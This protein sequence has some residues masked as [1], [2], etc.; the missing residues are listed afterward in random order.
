[1]KTKKTY[2]D[3]NP[4]KVERLV[5]EQL[6][7][8]RAE[9]E[10]SKYP[11]AKLRKRDF[12]KKGAYYCLLHPIIW[13]Y[14]QF[15]KSR[16]NINSSAGQFQQHLRGLKNNRDPWAVNAPDMA[17]FRQ[18]LMHWGI[19]KYDIGNY[20]R[21]MQNQMFIFALLGLWGVYLLTGSLFAQLN[22][23]PLTLIGFIMVVTR[24]W[25][26]QILVNRRFVFF[27]D[28]FLWGLFSWVGTETPFA[29]KKRL[30]KEAQY[31]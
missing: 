25:R 27:K 15:K 19:N 5:Q 31:E 9:K 8:E 24:I 6:A 18:V 26:I 17:D 30:E 16:N 28:W 4:E 11:K 3:I 10:K 23:L 1:M 21:G 13:P 7:K 2:P 14:H 12:L 29:R 22:G 20:V